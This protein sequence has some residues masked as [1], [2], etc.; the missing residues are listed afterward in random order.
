MN[1]W[2]S[3]KRIW[4]WPRWI[5]WWKFPRFRLGNTF[6]MHVKVESHRKTLSNCVVSSS[7]AP[8]KQRHNSKLGKVQLFKA[9][10]SATHARVAIITLIDPLQV[11]STRQSE[12]FTVIA[13]VEKHWSDKLQC[14][15]CPR[16][17]HIFWRIPVCQTLFSTT[18][19]ETQL[20]A[21]LL[22]A[23][24]GKHSCSNILRHRFACRLV[25]GLIVGRSHRTVKF[26]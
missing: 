17:R 11:R 13:C 19:K 24:T 5:N 6:V 7:T 8:V 12:Q 23:T 26:P 14:L 22:T 15:F 10:T 21:N 2:T 9:V 16:G 25:P 18:Y 1:G 4:R 20:R 3:F